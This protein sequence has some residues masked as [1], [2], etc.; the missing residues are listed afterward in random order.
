MYSIC[1]L[2]LFEVPNSFSISLLCSAKV[3]SAR[4]IVYF[5]CNS[6]CCFI[7]VSF[8]FFYFFSLFGK[9]FTSVCLINVVC[10]CTYVCVC[11][12]VYLMN[13]GGVD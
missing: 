7:A 6:R 4:E 9:V 3:K 5:L 1:L 11:V 8:F 10:M 12:H 13:P 2:I